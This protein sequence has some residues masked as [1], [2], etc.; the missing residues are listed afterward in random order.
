MKKSTLFRILL[1]IIMMIAGTTVKAQVAVLADLPGA[2]AVYCSTDQVKIHANSTASTSFVWQRYTGSGTSGT[3][4]PVAGQTTAD[5][6]DATITTP[7][8]Y[9]Y[10]STGSNANCQSD[11]SDPIIVYV[12]PNITASVAGPAN[13]CVNTITSNVLTS[14]VGSATTVPETFVYTYQWYKGSTAIAGATSSTYTLT[15]TDAATLGNA[16]FYVKAYYKV[17][18]A[19][20]EGT[21]TAVTVNIQANPTKPI[22][23]ITP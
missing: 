2:A 3:A 10:V 23:T 4:T 22:L 12:L 15:A 9:T 7:G 16:S 1:P 14:T 6:V 17:R 13:A 21:A 11:V 20:T 19:C 8:Y 18:P 5:L